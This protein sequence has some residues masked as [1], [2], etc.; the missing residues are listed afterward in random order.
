M[1]QR[2]RINLS[3]S[4]GAD[5]DVH[6]ETAGSL[7]AAVFVLVHAAAGLRVGAPVLSV[8]IKGL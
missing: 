3:I 4:A 5:R 6:D 2:A 1:S 8:L 7:A